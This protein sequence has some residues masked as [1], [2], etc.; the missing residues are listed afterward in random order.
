MSLAQVQL[1]VAVVVV[2]ILTWAGLLISAA[3]LLPRHAERA[4]RLLEA[5]PWRSAAIG[6][7]MAFLLGVLNA[8]VRTPAPLL[9]FAGILGMLGIGGVMALGA[10]GIALLMGRRIGALSGASTSFGALVRGSLVYS[11]AVGFPFIGWWLFAPISILCAMGAGFAALLP[12]PRRAPMPA[13]QA[14]SF[15]VA[16][17]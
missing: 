2:L 9:R 4:S 11:L 7:G 5:A 14:S 16:G 13:Q 12:E 3:L 17:G 6:L 10:A 15:D 1:G 8:L